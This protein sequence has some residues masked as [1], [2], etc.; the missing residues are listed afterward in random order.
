MSAAP[1]RPKLVAQSLAETRA[2]A[3]TPVG[4]SED[5]PCRA[6]GLS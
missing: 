6:W 5:T 1:G 2:R 4:G 3:G